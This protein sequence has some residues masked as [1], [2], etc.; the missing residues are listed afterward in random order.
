MVSHG[1]G[2]LQCQEVDV[3]GGVDSLRYS[4]DVV[5]YGYTTTKLRVVLNVIHTVW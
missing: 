4:I 3:I 5:G 2:A 1:N